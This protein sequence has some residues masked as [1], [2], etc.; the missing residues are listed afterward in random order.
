[1]TVEGMGK[2]GFVKGSGDV[3]LIDQGEAKTLVKYSGELQIGGKVASVGQR[4]FDTVSKSMTKQ[5]FDKLNEILLE[6][7]TDI[8]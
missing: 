3:E 7:S 8:K 1:M 6:R 5:G 2:I 4:M